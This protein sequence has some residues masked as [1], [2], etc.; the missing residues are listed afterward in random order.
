MFMDEPLI[1]TKA[2]DLILYLFPQIAKFPRQQR[3]SLGERIESM[4]LDF[5]SLLVEARYT[6][7]KSALLRRANILL[8][9]TRYCIRLCKDLKI[10]NLHVYEVLSKHIYE[11][12]TQLG[13][14]LKQA[15][16]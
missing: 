13:G 14:W 15:R 8:E 7:D 9:K 2:Y 1:I 10:M 16:A 6:R 3:Y 12:G 5:L 11:I 4:T